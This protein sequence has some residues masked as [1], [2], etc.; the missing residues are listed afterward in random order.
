MQNVVKSDEIKEI[1]LNQRY[2]TKNN[3]ETLLIGGFPVRW[4]KED[5]KTDGNIFS[6]L[7]LEKE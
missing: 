3:F 5:E 6:L 1:V 4:M 2:F 7:I